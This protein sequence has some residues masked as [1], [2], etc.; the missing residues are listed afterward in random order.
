M[1]VTLEGIDILSRL[2]HPLKAFFPILVTVL[3]MT[4]PVNLLQP[5]KQAS[6]IA[7]VPSLMRHDVM[8]S[9][10]ALCATVPT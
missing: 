5:L 7:V 1:D 6:S 8:S 10:T 3:G 4:T 9:D 2:R